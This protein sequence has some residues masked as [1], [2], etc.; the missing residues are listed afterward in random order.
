MSTLQIHPRIELVHIEEVVE[1]DRVRFEREPSE[2]DLERVAQFPWVYSVVT[3]DGIVQGYTLVIPVDHFAHNALQL[4]EMGE[5]ELL[6]RH[7]RKPDE[8]SAFYLA[9]VAT[10]PTT[11]PLTRRQ[12]VGLAQGQVM[13]SEVETF[14]IAIS[15]EGDSIA[16]ELQMTPRKYRGPFSGL[17]KY[18]PTLFVQEPF[19]F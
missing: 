2:L 3:R 7:I 18:V 6:L 14:A 13:R 8:C 10:I 9:S 12:I 15:R 17:A 1:I 16:R 11:N 4:G 5:E 19:H